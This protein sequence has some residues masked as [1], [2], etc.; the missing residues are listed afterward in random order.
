MLRDTIAADGSSA[1][2]CFNA[3]ARW[4]AESL[5][6]RPNLTPFAVTRYGFAGPL[7]DKLTVELSDSTRRR[8]GRSLLREAFRGPRLLP[9]VDCDRP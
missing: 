7:A 1:A 3:S 2:S 4:N 6:L 5:A 8:C 9:N